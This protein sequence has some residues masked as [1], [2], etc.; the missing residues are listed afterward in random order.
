MNWHCL[1]GLLPTDF[2]AGSPFDVE[3]PQLGCAALRGRLES[4]LEQGKAVAKRQSPTPA[5]NT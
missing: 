4:V 1:C 5:C 3:S 2:F